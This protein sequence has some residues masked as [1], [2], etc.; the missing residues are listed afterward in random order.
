V[1]GLEATYNLNTLARAGGTS[2]AYL[3]DQGDITQSFVTKLLN[4]S[5]NQL[6]CE[7]EIP[8]PDPSLT[9]DLNRVQV[10]YTPAVGDAEEIPKAQGA[11]DCATSVAGGW[12]Y[13]TPT[14]PSK[15]LVCPCTCARF[16]AGRVDVRLGCTPTPEVDSLAISYRLDTTDIVAGSPVP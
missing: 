3:V 16:A 6:S 2:S 11:G 7:Y 8:V 1:L 10:V 15:I 9:L 5:A 14:N 12:Y 13:D 4:I